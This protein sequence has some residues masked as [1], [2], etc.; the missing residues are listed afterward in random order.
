DVCRHRIHH[1]PLTPNGPGTMSWEEVEC[2]G[3]CVNAPVVM[4]GKDTYE[5]LSVERFEEIVEAFAAGRGDTIAP[6][7][8]I[9]RIRSA[10]AGGQTTLLE[11]PTA[12]RTRMETPP[13]AP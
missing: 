11:E 7:P 10:A 5:D 4:I 13:P 8:Q 1:D 2:I 9:E 6:G 12:E 3:A